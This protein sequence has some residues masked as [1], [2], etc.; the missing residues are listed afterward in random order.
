MIDL[1]HRPTASRRL[2]IALLAPPFLPV[3]PSHY[4]GTERVIGLL[5]AGL[6]E[7][8]HQVTLF[9]PAD[10]PARCRLVP[11]VARALWP[12]GESAP[13]PDLLRYTARLALARQAEF[14]LI[15]SHLEGAGLAL[16]AAAT[17]PVVTTLHGPLDRDATLA[18]IDRHP[19]AQLIAI[20][21]SQRRQ[22]PLASWLATIPNATPLPA[23]AGDGG[24][25][26][27]CFVGRVSRD[28]GIAEAID[29]ARQSGLRLVVAA[30]AHDPS[31]RELFE[32]VVRPA[33]A[34]G[35]VDFRG[36]VEPAARDELYADALA[37]V[38]LNNWP[39]P[40]GLVAAE[41]MAVGTPVI[42]RRLGALLE[43]VRDGVDG[44]LV[45]DVD[46]ALAALDGVAR[47]DRARIRDD[48]RRR[49]SVS[50]MVDGY[51]MAY[52]RLLA[53][54]AADPSRPA[55]RVARRQA[56]NV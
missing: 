55:S 33:I 41:S 46:E 26:Y 8:G 7:R 1:E 22:R 34:E 37:T 51:E 47:L 31:E 42:G 15:H 20:S 48:A 54:A 50:Q 6:S 12:R 4:G 21:H 32:Q 30:K 11:T 28:K 40:F 16:A 49:F 3:P 9:A 36:E 23:V 10:S 17:V 18:A 52:R 29:L 2:R 44:F 38:M 45:D 53:E 39:E 14:D 35:V 19:H 43:T 27:L 56:C 13:R 5:A 25:G 24:G